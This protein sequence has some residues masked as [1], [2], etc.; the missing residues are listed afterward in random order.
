M[1]QQVVVACVAIVLAVSSAVLGVSVVD[2]VRSNAERTGWE[3]VGADTLVV[4]DGLTTKVVAQVVGLPGVESVAAVFSADSV[5]LD[6]RTGI[7][8][9]R[10]IGVDPEALAAAGE[11]RAAAGGGAPTGGGEL[12]CRRVARPG[13]GRRGWPAALRAVGVPLQ[14]TGRVAR[15]PGVTNGESFVA[16]DLASLAAAVD[17]TLASYD[18]LLIRGTPTS[19][20]WR[21]RPRAFPRSSRRV[22]RAGR[23]RPARPARGRSARCGCSWRSW[24]SPRWSRSSRWCWSSPSVRHG[25]ARRR[26]CA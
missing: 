25:D 12:P 4:A 7:E 13:A 8:G 15:I 1:A 20:R 16:V 9:V 5:S 24:R 26:C 14:V 10:V 23:R 22:A 18:T 21:P 6:T 3:Q 11:G 2:T 19:T 17:R